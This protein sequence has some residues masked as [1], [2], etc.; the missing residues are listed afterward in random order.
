MSRAIPRQIQF[1]VS[2]SEIEAAANRGRKPEPGFV[3]LWLEGRM[4]NYAGGTAP[5]NG[6]LGVVYLGTRTKLGPDI[7]V[8]GL[9]Q[10][11]RGI[12]SADVRRKPDGGD[13]L[14]GRAL[15]EHEA[16][17]GRR[18]RWPRGVG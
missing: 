7:L 10:L 16:R 14:D 2:L 4:R 13:R 18:I 12:E 17:L 5:S 15:H 1:S 9:A 8:G 6:N 3:D 11:D